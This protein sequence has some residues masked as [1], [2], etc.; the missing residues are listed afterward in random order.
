MKTWPIA[1]LV[2]MLT[3]TI[4]SIIGL[5]LKQFFSDDVQEIVFQTVGLGTLI[6]GIKMALRLPEGYLLAF[7][8]SLIVGAVLGQLVRVDIIM[9]DLSDS[10]KLLS[11]STDGRFT[12]G[13]ISAFLLFCVGSMTIIGALEEGLQQKRELLYVKSI[14][15]GFS[16]IVLASTYGSGV[17]FSIIPMLIFQGGI[18]MAASQLKDI[19]SNI[20]LDCL[21][22]VGGILIIAI[23]FHLLKIGNI[24]LENL[25]PSLALIIIISYYFEKYLSNKAASVTNF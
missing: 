2:N 22:A 13:L 3:V 8:F 7:M 5:Y 24:W 1:T 25:L 6:I 15:D 18:T 11:G 14:L 19:F 21:S 9:T 16:S 10:L 4:G 12:E 17:L 23:S 20:V